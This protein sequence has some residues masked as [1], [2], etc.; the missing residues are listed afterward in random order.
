MSNDADQSIEFQASKKEVA[1]QGTSSNEPTATI[2]KEG[3]F[4]L[5]NIAKVKSFVDKSKERYGAKLEED[6][7]DKNT[8][9]WAMYLE[10]FIARVLHFYHNAMPDGHNCI[11]L[12]LEEPEYQLF[13]E[14]KRQG[15]PLPYRFI[16]RQGASFF[17][18]STTPGAK[19]TA[20]RQEFTMLMD[21]LQ[22]QGL[23]TYKVVGLEVF[24]PNQ[25]QLYLAPA[26]VLDAGAMPLAKSE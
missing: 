26:L 16:T 5:S 18:L 22:E 12:I 21:K 14:I 25:D 9:A 11:V 1:D 19:P 20:I 15:Q 7:V 24:H 23:F 8:K 6:F 4:I 3:S 2:P 13:T 17:E 10:S